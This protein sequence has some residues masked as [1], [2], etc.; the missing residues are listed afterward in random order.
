MR[1]WLAL[2]HLRKYLASIV[3]VQKLTRGRNARINIWKDKYYHKFRES[4]WSIVPEAKRLSRILQVCSILRKLER[5]AVNDA[6][7]ILSGGIDGLYSL[8]IL[9]PKQKLLRNQIG[10]PLP[11]SISY[12]LRFKH[13]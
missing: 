12:I 1:A 4:V 2:F 5:E 6:V 13:A 7:G 9:V 8:V 10:K 11:G 3:F